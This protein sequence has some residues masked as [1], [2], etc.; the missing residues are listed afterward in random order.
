MGVII[1]I[2]AWHARLTEDYIHY[3]LK[4]PTEDI[5]DKPLVVWEWYRTPD[6]GVGW[7]RPF[8]TT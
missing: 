2:V 3:G 4:K 5:W 7:H 8:Q 1:T 6:R